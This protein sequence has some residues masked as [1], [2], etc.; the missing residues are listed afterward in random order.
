MITLL[1]KWLICTHSLD[2]TIVLPAFLLIKG[3]KW[4]SEAAGLPT[5]PSPLH[6]ALADTRR[7]FRKPLCQTHFQVVAEP[8]MEVSRWVCLTDLVDLAPL[9]LT[10]SFPQVSLC[11]HLSKALWVKGVRS[12]S[13][14]L[15]GALV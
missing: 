11:A 9:L 6:M 13:A 5:A 14:V 3:R 15:G 8:A 7:L 12:V 2:I 4:A 10:L 1:Y